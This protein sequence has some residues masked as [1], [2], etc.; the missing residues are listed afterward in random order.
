ME[1]NPHMK[2][3]SRLPVFARPWWGARDGA[4]GLEMLLHEVDPI[5]LV[6]T[7]HHTT[8]RAITAI[9]CKSNAF[10]RVEGASKQNKKHLKLD[11]VLKYF[12]K[13]TNFEI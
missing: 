5:A 3:A 7:I 13:Q 2:S 11:L 8:T 1:D 6:S 12:V 4:D 10:S 9:K